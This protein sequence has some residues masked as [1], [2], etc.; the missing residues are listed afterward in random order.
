MYKWEA[1]DLGWELDR[2]RIGKAFC[3]AWTGNNVYIIILVAIDEY[4]HSEQI[5]RLSHIRLMLVVYT[6]P[7]T[8]SAAPQI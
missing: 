8:A 5:Q 3:I 6:V 2:S 7:E 1:T 4:D